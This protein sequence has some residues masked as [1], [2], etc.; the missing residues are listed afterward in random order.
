[1]HD[2]LIKHFIFV[3]VS[4]EKMNFYKKCFGVGFKAAVEINILDNQ[5]IIWGS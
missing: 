1:M 2:S 3:F 5:A 4:L